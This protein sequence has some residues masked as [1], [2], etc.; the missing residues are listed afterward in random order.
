MDHPVGPWIT[1]VD[2]I[3]NPCDTQFTLVDC[4]VVI[5]VGYARTLIFGFDELV[6]FLSRILTLEPGD[7]ITTSSLGFDGLAYR[8]DYRELE[9]PYLHVRCPQ[10]GDTNNPIVD[11]RYELSQGP[12][13]D[14]WD[15]M[16][17]RE[18]PS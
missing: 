12:V 11:R 4:G 16:M 15:R 7:L 17:N 1:T 14:P 3:D 6:H 2:E 13:R 8:P 5:D 18:A 9:D 10:L